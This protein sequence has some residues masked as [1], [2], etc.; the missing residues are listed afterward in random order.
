MEIFARDVGNPH[1]A[2][3]ERLTDKY[4]C[5]PT[6][7]QNPTTVRSDREVGLALALGLGPGLGFGDPTM[8]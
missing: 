6:A 4:L 5:D 8:L 1:S 3:F 7:A 2:R